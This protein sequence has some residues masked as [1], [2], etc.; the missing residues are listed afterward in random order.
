[1]PRYVS[2]LRASVSNP[3]TGKSSNVALI[4]LSVLGGCLE[5]AGL[6]APGQNCE[7]VADWDGRE[8]RL[9][10]QII[11]K[12]KD[13]RAGIKFDHLEPETERMLRQVCA[14]LR[15]QPLA[16]LPPEPA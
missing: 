15:L 14:N 5:G 9:P 11:W 4:T 7:I 3:A 2:E 6:P 16:P 1:M 13:K 8:L 12:F 10:G